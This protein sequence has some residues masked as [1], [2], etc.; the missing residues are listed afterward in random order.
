MA[1]NELSMRLEQAVDAIRQR[2]D[3]EPRLGIVLGSGLGPL[4][5]EAADSTAI[6]YEDIPHFAV[7]TAQ[8]H[9][10][11]LV[12]GHMAGQPVAV[13]S[14]RVHLYEGYMPA[15]VVFPIQTM[16]LL[17]VDT[18]LITNA[19]GGVNLHMPAGSLMLITDHINLTGHNP[20]I[21]PHDARLGLRFP[22]M[23]DAYSARLREVAR[24]AAREV[25]VAL[26]EGVYMGVLGPSFETPAEIRMAR[27]LG[28][29]A[30]GM[31][32]V[33]EVIA[34]NHCGMRVLGISCI[35]N[36]AAGILPQPV[37][38]QEVYD[39]AEQVRLPFTRLVHGI[40]A[41]YAADVG[42]RSEKERQR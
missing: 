25:N 33:M 11:K 26:A 32:T 14:G 36:M 42:E 29:D 10:G 2:S 34:A 4:A 3:L 15:Q 24:G 21:G 20:L 7:S 30:V 13:M 9:A 23:S 1:T 37:T 12:L 5:E 38:A 40:I 28:A 16:R 39:R 8:G 18:L 19:A 41:A 22:D 27:T 17:G 35:T 6:S 31:S